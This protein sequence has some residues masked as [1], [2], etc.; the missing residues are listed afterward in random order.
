MVGLIL[1]VAIFS[2]VAAGVSFNNDNYGL[3]G[4]NLSLCAFN[5]FNFGVNIGV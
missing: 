1:F 5:C 2:G 3:A 4:L